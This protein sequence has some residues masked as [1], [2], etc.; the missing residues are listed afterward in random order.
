MLEPGQVEAIQLDDGARALLA[1]GTGRASEPE[2]P[3]DFAGAVTALN[4]ASFDAK[5]SAIDQQIGRA[6]SE[7]QSLMR[8]SY[9]VFCLKKKTQTR[10]T[11]HKP[12]HKNLTS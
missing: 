1:A 6:P 9:A 8:I 4:A 11:R 7:L 10:H 12:V 5:R 2:A 3:L